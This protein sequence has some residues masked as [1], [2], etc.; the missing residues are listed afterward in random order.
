MVSFKAFN[1]CLN[2]VSI[3]QMCDLNEKVKQLEKQSQILRSNS[4]KFRNAYLEMRHKY[5]E[6]IKDIEQYSKNMTISAKNRN[7]VEES[8]ENELRNEKNKSKYF[9]NKT[10]LLIKE[11]KEM[12]ERMDKMNA[13]IDN[14]DTKIVRIERE[15]VDL[16]KRCLE[17]KNSLDLQIASNMKLSKDYERGLTQMKKRF[18]AQ[19]VGLNKQ[20]QYYQDC[21]ETNV[22]LV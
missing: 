3:K 15:S 8:L 19:N 9:E 17:L 20:K 12:T 14:R 11:K 18:E 22:C 4:D 16:N 2:Y 21:N 1:N 7:K 13:I 5:D 6:K 10:D